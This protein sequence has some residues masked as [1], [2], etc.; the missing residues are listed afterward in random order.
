[1]TKERFHICFFEHN[2]LHLTRLYISEADR[3]VSLLMKISTSPKQYQKLSVIFI[4]TPCLAEEQL[5]SIILPPLCFTVGIYLFIYFERQT[6]T[7]TSFKSILKKFFLGLTRSL[8]F[9]KMS[10]ELGVRFSPCVLLGFPLNTSVSS[11]I[12]KTS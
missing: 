6:Y 7:F 10:S 11:L 5:H 12:Q 3:S 2:M 8:Y 4:Q 1:M 9:L